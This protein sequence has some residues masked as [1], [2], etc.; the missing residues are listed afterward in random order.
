MLLCSDL[1]ICETISAVN[2]TIHSIVGLSRK[3]SD[4][5]RNYIINA[6]SIYRGAGI[7]VKLSGIMATREEFIYALHVIIDTASF[8]RQES[9]VSVIKLKE[10][11]VN[12]PLIRNRFVF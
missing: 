3:L 5:N 2:W 10:R 11:C 7:V 8:C 12:N 1:T 4:A 6:V 9:F